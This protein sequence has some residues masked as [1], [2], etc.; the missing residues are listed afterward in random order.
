MGSLGNDDNPVLD[1]EFQSHLSSGLSVTLTN[2]HQSLVIKDAATAFC[3]RT[4]CLQCHIV[5]FQVFQHLL[6][7]VEYMGLTLIH[8]GHHLRIIHNLREC[9]RIEVRYADSLEHA[10]IVKFFER[11]PHDGRVAD[12]PVNQH[13]VHI[14]KPKQLHG[15]AD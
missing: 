12:R 11:M 6:L 8:Y 14:A 2:T 3:Q 5:W 15:M 7:L 10:L 1:K 9:F 13:Q 4:P